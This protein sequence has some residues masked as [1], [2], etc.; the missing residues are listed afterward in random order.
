MNRKRLSII[1]LL[2]LL[3]SLTPPVF[4]GGIKVK[5]VAP[6]GVI[7]SA[8]AA[9][10]SGKERPTPDGD[11]K[12]RDAVAIDFS[13]VLNPRK[14]AKLNIETGTRYTVD[15]HCTGAVYVNGTY[16][17]I[18]VSTYHKGFVAIIPSYLLLSILDHGAV[19]FVSN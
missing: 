16:Y 2:L 4:A 19:V 15:G 13:A 9:W 5:S 7:E 12:L 8:T 17:A 1:A 14:D 11:W 3:S 18:R 6:I 10:Y